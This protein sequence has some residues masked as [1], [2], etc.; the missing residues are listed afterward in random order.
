MAGRTAAGILVA[1]GLL[2]PVPAVSDDEANTVANE[3]GTRYTGD[4][5]SRQ[6]PVT[7]EL[8]RLEQRIDDLETSKVAREDATR[9]ILRQTFS[10]W[11][12]RINEFVVLGGTF[13]FA[14]VWIE[15]FDRSSDAAVVLNTVE[16]DFEIQV[17]DWTTGSIVIEYDD[18]QRSSFLNESGDRDFVDRINIDTAIV[19]LGDVQRFPAFGTFGRMI[20]PGSADTRRP[21]A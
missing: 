3:D 19:S 6:G 2:L 10:E 4:A 18:G 11:G 12:S 8:E 15:D 1:F 20:V 13:E 5:G 21:P 9:S 7:R 14:G 16:F 17:N